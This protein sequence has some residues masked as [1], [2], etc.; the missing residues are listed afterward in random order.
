M[1]HLGAEPAVWAL[2]SRLDV[3][4]PGRTTQRLTLIE[5]CDQC[6]GLRIVSGVP[7]EP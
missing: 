7:S 5:Y 3:F 4:A 1:P 6:R 2:E